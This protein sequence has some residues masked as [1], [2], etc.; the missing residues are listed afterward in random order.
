MRLSLALRRGFWCIAGI[1]SLRIGLAAFAGRLGEAGIASAMRGYTRGPEGF[2]PSLLGAV[3]EAP[4]SLSSVSSTLGAAILLGAVAN[5]ITVGGVL[6]HL[7]TPGSIGAFVNNAIRWAPAM[8][9][10]T[11]WV[12][13]LRLL[14]I[15]VCAILDAAI[16]TPKAILVGA[17][18]WALTMPVHDHA[19]AMI[20]EGRVT[21]RYGPRALKAAIVQ[22]PRR[23]RSVAFSAGAWLGTIA[24]SLG[25][26]AVG[27]AFAE[28]SASA[29]AIRGLGLLAV[30]LTV[31]RL[32]IAVEED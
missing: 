14:I 27:F 21:H 10:S 23:L 4:T 29:W 1:A 5:I 30:A 18:L 17:L 22:S 32:S 8:L 26:G 25:A 6:A 24:C 15:A 19:R 20:I 12:T 16:G 13:L 7:R 9:T 2:L 3:S 11:I 28:S 31:L